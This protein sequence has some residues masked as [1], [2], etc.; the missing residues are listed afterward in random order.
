MVRRADGP[1]RL[2]QPARGVVALHAARRAPSADLF[3][4]YGEMRDATKPSAVP[5]QM[6]A[7]Y[8]AAEYRVEA[9]TRVVLRIGQRSAEL[10]GLMADKGMASAAFITACNPHGQLLGAADNTT[11]TNALG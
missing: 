4:L 1:P 3:R 6:I 10:A 8:D 5:A 11:R 7:A 2:Q 9:E